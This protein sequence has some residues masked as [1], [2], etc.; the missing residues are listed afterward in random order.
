MTIR[1]PLLPQLEGHRLRIVLA[2]GRE[3][4]GEAFAS[5]ADAL[6]LDVDDQLV[7]IPWA[8]VLT[9]EVLVDDIPAPRRR[10]R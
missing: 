2:N 9:A 3:L 6:G 10:K 7:V 8:A 1:S 5:R 4:V